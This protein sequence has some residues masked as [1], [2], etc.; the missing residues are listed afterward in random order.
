MS[1]AA[2]LAA[3]VTLVL[4]GNIGVALALEPTGSAPIYSS[5][6]ATTFTARGSIDQIDKRWANISFF[7]DAPFW[8]PARAGSGKVYRWPKDTVFVLF[9][10]ALI[11]ITIDG[12]KASFA[13]LVVGQ[14]IEVQYN[15]AEGGV[16]CL[17]YRIDA[18]SPRGAASSGGPPHPARLAGHWRCAGPGAI[19]DY[20]FA[21][22]G[23]FRSEVVQAD[24]P[25]RGCSGTWSLAG[26]KLSYVVTKSSLEY[27]P[28]GKRDQDK[29]LQL[30]KDDYVIETRRGDQHR[31][32][33]LK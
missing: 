5:G 30:T 32:V 1:R 8:G 19:S 2:F 3:L 9:V 29:I 26:D 15:M 21:A 7:A 12:K 28:A 25:V 27:Y 24:K 20:W 14:K 18:H 13:D 33:R 17:A 23:T 22:D 6:Q 11:P 16:R 10:P 4:D 31:Y